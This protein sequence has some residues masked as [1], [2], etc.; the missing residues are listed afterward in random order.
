MRGSTEL[1]PTATTEGPQAANTTTGRSKGAKRKE[2]WSWFPRRDAMSCRGAS[3]F[4]AP[5][6][7]PPPSQQTSHRLQRLMPVCLGGGG[8]AA[9]VRACHRNLARE[10]LVGCGLKLIPLS[11]GLGHELSNS[12]SPKGLDDLTGVCAG[13]VELLGCA[14]VFFETLNDGWHSDTWSLFYT[15]VERGGGA[16]AVPRTSPHTWFPFLSFVLTAPQKHLRLCLST[17]R[18]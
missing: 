11:R 8:G 17:D 5:Q 14:S 4:S 12:I 7:S 6:H 2:L 10:P 3:S 1:P 16:G 15:S 18:T 13:W 9:C